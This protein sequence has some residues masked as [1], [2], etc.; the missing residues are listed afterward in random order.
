MLEKIFILTLLLFSF[1]SVNAEDASFYTSKSALSEGKWVKIRIKETGFYKLTYSDLKKM[2]FSDP[3]KVSVHGYG[4]FPMEED[5]SKAV[6][7][8]DVPSV[9]VY[10]GGDYL[11]FYGKGV[12]KWTYDLN[13]KYF[14][15]ENNTYSTSGYYFVTDATE[16]NEAAQIPDNTVNPDIEISAYD[17]YRLHEVEKVSITIPG[18][19]N[20]GRDLFGESFNQK[21]SQ[22]FTFSIPGITNDTGV[23]S[24]RFVAKLRTASGVVSMSADGVNLTSNTIAANTDTYVAALSV[25]PKVNWAGEKKENT[26][27]NISFSV[28]QQT[29]HL[30]Y[31]R[32]QFKR[33]LQSYGACTFFRSVAALK[34]N[35]KF[36]ISNAY[37]SNYHVFDV[38]E[39][40][41]VQLL[42]TSQGGAGQ[43]FTIP[44]DTVIREFALLDLTQQFP[45]PEIAGEIKNQNLHGLPQTD[46]VILAPEAFV[47]EAERL[48]EFHR[49]HDKL[50]V[51]VTVPERIYNEYSSGTPEA[52]AIRRFMKMFY[53]RKTSDEDAPKYLL[54]FGDGRF[55]NR[56]LTSEW[57]ANTSENYLLTYQSKESIGESSYVSDD[58]FGFLHDGQGGNPNIAS[59]DIGIG[60]FP[61]ST[62]TQAQNAVYKIITYAE[63]SNPGPWKNN[64]CFIAD[65]GNSSDMFDTRHM[66]E[67][68]QSTQML[69]KNHPQYVTK[70]LFFDAFKINY[71]GGKPSYPD[72]KTN[73]AKELKNGVLII[74][75]TGHGDAESWSEERVITQTDI[76]NAGYTNL[77]L[78]ITASCVFAPFDAPATSAGEN[79]FLN[80]RSGGIALYTTARVAYSDVNLIMNKSLLENLFK[81]QNGRHLTLGEVMKNMKNS[82]TASHKKLSFILLGDPALTLAFPD[83]YDMQITEINGVPV[84][85]QP[86]NIR[87][88]EKVT[89]KGKVTNQ[90]G[91]TANDF[92]GL[93]SATVYDSEMNITTLD[94]NNTGK[95][96]TYKDYPNT[97]YLGNDSVRNGEF[98]FSFTVPK[99]ISY[100]NSFGKLNL[101]ASD[102]ITRKEANGAYKNF[103]VGG[104]SDV[105]IEDTVGPEIR[106]MYLNTHD[107]KEGDKVNSTPVFVAIVW[108]KSGIN[109]GSSS[110]GHDITLTIDGNPAL[111]YSLNSYYQTYLE[112]SENEG[113]VRF[114]LPALETGR[115]TAEFKVWDIQNNSSVKTLAFNV[116]DNY[117][118]SIAD[119]TAGPS[120]AREFVN[121]RIMHDMPESL[122][123]VRIEVYDMTGQLQWK[124]EETG[125][126]GISDS[127][128]VRWDLTNNAGS[129]LHPGIYVYRAILSSNNSQEVSKTKKLIIIAQ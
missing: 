108:D 65:D 55:D 7:C 90:N 47:K 44:A 115:H 17:D 41:P 24:F 96:F 82:Y 69:E 121:F 33:K 3:L 63:N 95:T 81:K 94:N 49:S 25:S 67:A 107:F 43:T 38:T 6:Y 68:D 36:Q 60:R 29:S 51:F 73:I 40:R 111:G 56:K 35:T 31:I 58:Y 21:T 53:D 78:W 120:P 30:D 19:P 92:T 91:E 70:K 86:V 34:K 124:H 2:G 98:S 109:V 74:D 113:I 50:T 28:S 64:L 84:S 79:V 61:V 45:Q 118:P 85:E 32:L 128:T 37:S 39:G 119:L 89:F 16:T 5:L 57:A 83:E 101:Y 66:S 20:S 103:T 12:V 22:D 117:K 125:I 13:G 72:V 1:F 77:P 59:L 112:G 46:M 26:N 106:D 114:P 100:S 88:F 126:S 52:S 15:H 97:I 129:R 42:Q 123:K 9:A 75:Y 8:D 48:A 102:D 104:T 127:Y 27:I 14:V 18:R 105:L 62:L 4:G 87:A 122:L 71:T 23:I 76:I 110:I 99:D 10:R 116:T 54:L 93:L 11:L 80:K